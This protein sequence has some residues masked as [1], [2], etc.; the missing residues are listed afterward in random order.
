MRSETCRA[1]LKCWLK[2][3]HWEHIVYLV[4]L[5]IYI[6]TVIFKRG[7]LTRHIMKEVR[8]MMRGFVCDWRILCYV[9]GSWAI[10]MGLLNDR[11]YVF[12]HGHLTLFSATWFQ[13][14]PSVPNTLWSPVAEIAVLGFSNFMIVGRSMFSLVDLRLFCQ[15]W[16]FHT[17]T[18]E[19]VYRSFLMCDASSFGNKLQWFH[20]QLVYLDFLLSYLFIG[21]VVIYT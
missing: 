3:T 9:E 20:L 5:Y 17:L 11:N 14:L 13:L 16:C 10:W 4:G 19:C 7:A 6:S 8:E 1:K 21:C 18:S 2:L 15:S 12:H